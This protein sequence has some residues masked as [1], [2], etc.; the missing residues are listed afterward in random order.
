MIKRLLSGVAIREAVGRIP[1]PAMLLRHIRT[2]PD[3]PGHVA[4]TLAGL[5]FIVSDI[6]WLR[7]LATASCTFQ[8]IFSTW[9][10]IGAS[11]WLPIRWNIFY[12]LVNS[13]YIAKLLSERFVRLTDEEHAVFASNFDDGSMSE[14]AFKTLIG[15]GRFEVA[16]SRLAIIRKGEANRRLILALPG[17]KPEVELDG[18]VIVMRSEGTMLGEVSFLH[19]LPA[20]ATVWL[21]AGCRYVIWDRAELDGA[22]QPSSAPM[23]GLELAISRQLSAKLANTTSVLVDKSRDAQLREYYGRAVLHALLSAREAHGRAGSAAALLNELRALR[24]RDGVSEEVHELVFIRLGLRDEAR[25]VRE[26]A[27]VGAL[28]D[29]V[30]GCKPRSLKTRVTSEMSDVLQSDWEQASGG[31]GANGAKTPLSPAGAGV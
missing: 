23:I 2:R 18:G 26:G 17:A 7:V 16:Q 21:P 5:S 9:H 11:L 12:I 8:L 25:L 6:L 10:P 27:T 22:L 13:A 4:F 1:G 31:V 28:C 29:A 14:R 3:W 19:G 20:S 15:M 24:A 30:M